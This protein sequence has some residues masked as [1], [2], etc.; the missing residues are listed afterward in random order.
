MGYLSASEVRQ[1][2]KEE[3]A[4]EI[5]ASVELDALDVALSTIKAGTDRIPADPAKESGKLTDIDTRLASLLAQDRSTWTEKAEAT[6][7]VA[8]ATRAAEAGKSHYVVA[9]VASYGAAQIGGL[10]INDGASAVISTHVHNAAVIAFP[11]PLKMTE[12]NAVS[13]A[14]GAGAAGVVGRVN[15]IGFTI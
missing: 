9:V 3:F 8:T 5:A 4:A 14:L 12:G 2:F 11:K 15:I 10:D 1:I 7:D 6:A 13:A